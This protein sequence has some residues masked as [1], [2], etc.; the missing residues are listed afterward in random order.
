MSAQKLTH[1]LE[2]IQ[3]SINWWVNKQNMVH[4][5]NGILLSPK[6]WNIS[7]IRRNFRKI[8]QSK[9]CQSQKPCVCKS[10]FVK[11]LEQADAQ[12]EKVDQ[13]CRGLGGGLGGDCPWYGASSLGDEEALMRLFLVVAQ[14]CEYTGN[15]WIAHFKGGDF[16]L[17]IL[18]QFSCY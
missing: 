7:A 9:R 18:F 8:T 1:K 2:T 15:H 10:I 5:C 4:L 11:R 17:W 12:R 6:K 13:W 16:S 3:M 14:L